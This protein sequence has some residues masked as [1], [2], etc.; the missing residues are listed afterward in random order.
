MFMSYKKTLLNA[1][2]EIRTVGCASFA[3][4]WIDHLQLPTR[5]IVISSPH[6]VFLKE[7]SHYSVILFA[8]MNAR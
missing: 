3:K 4:T 8:S 5:N 1:I 7:E 6:R 2:N